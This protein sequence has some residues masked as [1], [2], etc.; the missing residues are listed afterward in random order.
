LEKKNPYVVNEHSLD[1]LDAGQAKK[2][3]TSFEI[4]GYFSALAFYHIPAAILM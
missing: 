1:A 3:G 2:I 4:L